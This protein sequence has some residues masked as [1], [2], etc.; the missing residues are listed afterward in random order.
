[1]NRFGQPEEVAAGV[2]YLLSDDA[3]YVTGHALP[4]DGGRL[5]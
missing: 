3:S 4:V 1:M 2:L 5:A